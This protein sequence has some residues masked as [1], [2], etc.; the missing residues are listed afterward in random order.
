MKEAKAVLNKNIEVQTEGL[1]IIP[2][3]SKDE[4]LCYEFKGKI[5][6]RNFLIYI[7]AKTGQEQ[8]VLLIIE[9]PGGVLT[10]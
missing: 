6:D 8:K 10:M 2:T 5:D 1:A 9:T 3:D 7:N 4:V